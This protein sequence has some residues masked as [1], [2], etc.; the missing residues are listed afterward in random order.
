MLIA[1]R[2]NLV[3]VLK[4]LPSE[5][6]YYTD[7]NK[8]IK[9]KNV[10]N[11]QRLARSWGGRGHRT[12]GS[13]VTVAAPSGRQFCGGGVRVQG[14]PPSSAFRRKRLIR[15][16]HLHRSVHWQLS[17][18]VCR[19]FRLVLSPLVRLIHECHPSFQRSRQVEL[20]YFTG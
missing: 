20:S 2:N 19:S 13:V 17:S 16:L 8:V 7:T 1:A 9:K 4:E 14:P 5:M 11:L 6:K 10:K 18:R 3:G 12:T 15:W